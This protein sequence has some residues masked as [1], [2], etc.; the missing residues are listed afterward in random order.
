MVAV[1]N[2]DQP[3]PAGP[4]GVLTSP[5]VPAVAPLVPAA[6]VVLMRD[7]AEGLEVLLLQRNS[8]RGAFAG[9]WVFPGGRVDDDDADD[10]ACA[11]REAAEETGLAIDR[12]TLVRWS[13]WIPPITEPRRFGTWFFL[14]PVAAGLADGDVA[15]DDGE[16]VGHAWLSPSEALR[17]RD[18]GEV[19]LAPPTFVTLT[20]LA[21]FGSTADALA[22]ARSSEPEQ[23]T[24]TM[25][26]EDAQL[27]VAW[28]PDAALGPDATLATPGPRHRIH[29]N[30]GPWVYDR[31]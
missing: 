24:T 7:G 1:S 18:V 21:R 27:V 4:D 20:C 31:S 30:S 10:V 22:H 9:Y 5:E 2:A 14:A 15:V 11:V 3:S 29:L 17:R 13:H 19:Q 28:E 25:I 16:I 26:R 12:N 8:G 23:F 6:T